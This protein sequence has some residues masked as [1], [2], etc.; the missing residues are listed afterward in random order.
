MDRAARVW[1]SIAACA[2]ARDSPPRVDHACLAAAVA[3]RVDG[4]A[5][6]IVSG[7][8][9]RELMFATDEL[10]EELAELQSI[11]GEGP[12]IDAFTQARPILVADVAAPEVGR[13]WPA[14]AQQAD[15]LGAAAMFSLPLHAGAAR[16]GALDLYR[17]RPGPLHPAQLADALVYADAALALALDEHARIQPWSAHHAAPVAG[18]TGEPAMQP[19]APLSTAPPTG[20]PP[21][22]SRMS[23]VPLEDLFVDR[24]VEIHQATG[25]VSAQLRIS[26]TEALARLR[27]YAFAHDQ[28]LRDVAHAVLQ[29]RLQLDHTPADRADTGGEGDADSGTPGH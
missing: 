20:L 21:G 9:V 6:V 1:A 10:A 28:R 4:A 8:A 24:G 5:L 29:R 19:P 27:A 11:L 26:V 15:H 3:L 16:L 2:A 23:Q 17:R 13:R 22:A 12:E 7:R 14:F 18:P 25:M